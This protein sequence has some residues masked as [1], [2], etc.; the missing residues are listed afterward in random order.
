MG[1][2]WLNFMLC[3]K[4]MHDFVPKSKGKLVIMMI[5]DF[6]VKKMLEQVFKTLKK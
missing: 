2:D 6:S 3:K 4:L 5:D 1:M